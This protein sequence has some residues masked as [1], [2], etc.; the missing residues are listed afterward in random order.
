MNYVATFV[1]CTLTIVSGC[2]HNRQCAENEPHATT[3]FF[4]EDWKQIPAE[5]PINQNHVQ[6]HD[7]VVSRHGPGADLIKKSHHDNIPNDPWYVWSG[8]CESKWALSLHKKDAFVNLN[9]GQIRWRTKQSGGHILH[10]ILQLHD[11]TWLVSQPVA[12][13]TADWQIFTTNLK[14][15]KWHHLNMD[16]VQMGNSIAQPDLSRVQSIGWTDLVKGGASAACSRVDWIE[17][18]GIEISKSN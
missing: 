1:F 15:L 14:P 16:T 3:L 17:V 6:N 12:E 9:Q 10:I 11:G 5:I 2:A 13:E 4:R 8:L 7:L 18:Y